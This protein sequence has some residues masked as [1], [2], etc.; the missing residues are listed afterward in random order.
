V[1]KLRSLDLA[2]DQIVL[3]DLIPTEVLIGCRDE[4]SAARVLPDML[5]SDIVPLASPDIAIDAARHYRTLRRLGVT[6]R[7]GI[8]MLI[9]TFC[10]RGGHSLLHDDRDFA[11]MQQHLGLSVL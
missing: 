10:I 8:D 1:R 6:V 4:T 3:G 2:G 5:C 7:T 11:V 9:G